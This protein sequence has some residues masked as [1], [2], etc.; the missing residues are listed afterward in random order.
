MGVRY[1]GNPTTSLSDSDELGYLASVKRAVSDEA[2]L[3]NFR[4]DPDYQKVL[5]HVPVSLG[6]KYLDEIVANYNKKPRST[7][8]GLSNLS[9]FGSPSV[10]NFSGVGYVSPTILRY[11]KVA[12]EM[13]KLFGELSSKKIGEIG[14]GF[15]GQ[16]AV[17]NR[18]FGVSE[19]VAFDLP[20]VLSLFE[21]FT[22]R[23]NSRL[24]AKA[25]DGRHP[26]SEKVDILVSNYAFSELSRSVQDEYL[27]KVILQAKS[28]YM[29]WNN[30]SS[31][32]LDGYSLKEIVRK[33]PG[34]LVLKETPPSAKANRLIVWGA[35][36]IPTN[37]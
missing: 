13:E 4:A 1:S 23:T 30:L 18:L 29:I 22:K 17:L 3:L 21:L 15:G 33:I 25:V 10:Y 34:S 19:Y 20:E 36:S 31:K 32:Y 2:F 9:Q 27:N 7:F 12:Y 37:L 8:A 26:K 14:V 35:S 5:E 24:V 11:V 6:K 28:G 16:A